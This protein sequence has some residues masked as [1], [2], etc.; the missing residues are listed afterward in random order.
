M[1]ETTKNF[2]QAVE[3]W[4]QTAT[5]HKI[6]Y[7]V[8]HD[9]H[10]VPVCYSMEHLPGLYVEIT[11]EQFAHSSP[12]VRVVDGKLTQPAQPCPP[13]LVPGTSGVACAL[14]DVSVVVDATQPHVKWKL[15][16]QR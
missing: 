12:H 15:V 14:D 8:Y 11:A 4:H 10:G 7:R 13:T 6:F 3:Q 2:F 9:E 16:T 1:N 5:D